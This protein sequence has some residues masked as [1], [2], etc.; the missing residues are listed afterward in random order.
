MLMSIVLAQAGGGAAQPAIEPV[1]SVWDFALKGGL[2]M[3]PLGLVSVVTLAIVIERLVMLRRSR[4]APPQFLTTLRSLLP[5]RARAL[6]AC[7]ADGSPIAVVLGTAIRHLGESPDRVERLVGEAG[8]REVLVLR[9]RMRLL[10]AVPQTAVMLGLL[11]TVFG[12]IKTFQSVAASGEA[13]GKA[14]LLARGIYEAW[15]ATASGLL[16]AVPSIIVY[17]WVLSKIDARAADIDRIAG[18]WVG[19]DGLLH[20]GSP[21]QAA[22]AS[23]MAQAAT[24][25]LAAVPV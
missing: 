10:S 5:D 22:S 15:T 19:T 8:Q 24:P 4:V 14:E 1:K 3:I 25:P 6:E 23:S 7:R 16:V 12:M 13:L 9:R 17:Q 20:Q 21:T 11:G 2:I 18:V